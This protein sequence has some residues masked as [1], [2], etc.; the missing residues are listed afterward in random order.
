MSRLVDYL[1]DDVRTATENEE[2][3]TDFGI[4][5]EEILRYLNDAQHRL[6]SLVVQQHSQVFVT[7]KESNIVA[8]QAE[9]T[10]PQNIYLDNKLSQ[11]EYSYDGSVT[12]YY[13]LKR[14][15]LKNRYPGSVGDPEFYVRRSGKILVT[16][17]PENSGG[18]LRF[19]YIKSVDKLDKRRGLV[20]TVTLD[21]A[22]STI[23]SLVLD[24]TTFETDT[25][26]LNKSSY[27][28]VVDSDGEIKMRNVKFTNIDSGSG[29]ITIDSSFTYGSGESITAGDYIVAGKN[30][31]THSELPDSTERY[32]IA[33]A[34]WKILKR[35]S[36]VDSAEAIQELASMEQEIVASF[37]DMSDDIDR[38]PEINENAWWY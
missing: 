18:K 2:F 26:T 16:P 19:S 8:N 30:A 21:S 24:V 36:S 6:H 37:A 34:S 27:F 15:V 38:I 23:T 1:I 11:V 5:E 22:T 33:Y 14:T 28:T 4:G 20:S 9:Y 31:T 17:I 7:E 29:T 32:L 10:L 12:E 35:D 13:P 3:A 25:T